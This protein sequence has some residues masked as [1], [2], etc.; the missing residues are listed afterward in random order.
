MSRTLN[1]AAL[2]FEF[3]IQFALGD[4]EMQG[5]RVSMQS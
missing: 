4:F 3:N 1:A 2:A 5:L